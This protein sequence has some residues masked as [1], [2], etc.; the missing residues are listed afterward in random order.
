MGPEG[1]SS[2]PDQTKSE[3]QAQRNET[4]RLTSRSSPSDPEIFTIEEAARILRCTVDTLRRIPKDEL[5][6]YRGPGRSNLYLREDL[7]QFVRS[8]RILPAVPDELLREVLD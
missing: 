4:T 5:P 1:M 6:V 2:L 8:R 3:S 7:K